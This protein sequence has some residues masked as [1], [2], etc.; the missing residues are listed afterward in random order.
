MD[1]KNSI[2]NMGMGIGNNYINTPA[3]FIEKNMMIWNNHTMIQLSNI[4]YLSAEKL[5]PAIFPVWTVLAIFAGLIMMMFGEGAAAVGILLWVASGAVLY[6]WYKDA[7]K[8]ENG[9]IL[10]I[11]MN[12]GGVLNFE[13][14]NKTFLWAVAEKIQ[15]IMINGGTNEKV[16][17]NIVNSVI[18][19]SSVLSGTNINGR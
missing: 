16:E 1:N 18:R 5:P 13:F 12:S 9:A 8:R 6:L 7:Q 4:S 15:D 17:I 14:E 10:H 2:N 3:I 19:D 11:K